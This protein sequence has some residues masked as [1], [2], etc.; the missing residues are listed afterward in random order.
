MKAVVY[1]QTGGSDVLHLVDRPVPEPG[2]GEVRVRVVGV[3]RESDRLEGATGRRGGRARGPGSRSRTRTGRAPSMPS[4][5]AS[6]HRASASG[7]GYGKRPGNGSTEPRRNTLSCPPVR[8]CHLPR[9]VVR[10]GRES[11]HPGA[12]R[13]HLPDRLG[14]RSR[15]LSQC[16]L[17]R[18]SAGCRR[19]RSGRSCCD[20]VAHGRS[21]SDRDS[22]RRR[23][24]RARSRGRG[25]SHRQLPPPSAAD[26]IL[27]IAPNGVDVIVEV[28]AGM[29]AALDTAVLAS[30]G[31][32]TPMRRTVAASW[33]SRSET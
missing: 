21:A 3:G 4:V 31:T 27:R 7:S 11:R 8:P 20:P 32:V 18:D 25:G 17:R 12:D 29:N 13:A 15:R 9:S 30:N 26:E 24:G 22:E 1:A 6:T 23:E 16:S 33:T 14:V 2:A 19:R 10:R 5:R 28:A